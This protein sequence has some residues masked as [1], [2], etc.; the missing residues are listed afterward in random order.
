MRCMK[1]VRLVRIGT[2][3]SARAGRKDIRIR[4]RD[5]ER[6]HVVRY[7]YDGGEWNGMEGKM[8]HRQTD[9]QTDQKTRRIRAR[10][11]PSVSRERRKDNRPLPNQQSTFCYVRRH[12]RSAI[13]DQASPPPPPAPPPYPASPAPQARPAQA[14]PHPHRGAPRPPS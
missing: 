13:S 10:T 7:M 2:S 5:H 11:T 4:R 8:K 14:R 1:V 6:G 12:Q 9:R 3:Y